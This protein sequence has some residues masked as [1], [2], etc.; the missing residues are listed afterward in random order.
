MRG[1]AVPGIAIQIPV[2]GFGCSTLSSVGEKNALELLGTAFDA[3]V[4]H[5][6]VARYYGYGDAEGMLGTFVKSRRVEV[7]ITTKFGIQP[8]RRTHALRFA[9][10][11]G[12]QLMRLVPCARSYMRR[13]AQ[14]L[15]K[16][17][18][19]SLKE[20]RESLETSLRELGT[21]YIDFYLLHDYTVS[22]HSSDELAGFLMDNVKAGKIRYFGIGT[23]IDNVLRA[24]ERQ[25]ELCRI[26]QFENS[27][28]R[29]NMDKL[30]QGRPDRLTITH[31]ALSASYRSVSVFLKAYSQLARNWSAKLGLDC[32]NDDTISALML[33]YAVQAN[34]NGLALFSSKNAFRVSKN[35][36]AVL[37]PGVSPA[38]VAL[39]G[40]LVER[41]LMP[42][43]LVE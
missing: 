29:R 35:V 20:A 24:L 12:R 41:D 18:G 14:G 4:R 43:M 33:N 25:P 2:I 7:T 1:I 37:E 32:S 31:G 34:Q 10:Q 15:V 28:L 26:L 3:G 17:G 30:P 27:V 19:F 13:R 39:F 38:Q 11:A 9:L 6:D 5:F 23:G 21:D 40:E 8:P 22:E 36:K 16:G 42:S